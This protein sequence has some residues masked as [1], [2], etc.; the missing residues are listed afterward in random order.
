MSEPYWLLFQ[1]PL[2]DLM[3]VFICSKMISLSFVLFLWF[4]DEDFTS[5]SFLRKSLDIIFYLRLAK[6]FRF[7]N[8]L[9]HVILKI[10]LYIIKQNN[11]FQNY[12]L[13]ILVCWIS[14]ARIILIIYTRKISIP[15]VKHSH[16]DLNFSHL[17]LDFIELLNFQVRLSLKENLLFTKWTI[18]TALSNIQ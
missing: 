3:T 11:T 2:L 18:R 8:I 15:I 14:K 16:Q 9:L 12:V 17:Q 4:S 5:I 7:L 1:L 6:K 13:R 10:K